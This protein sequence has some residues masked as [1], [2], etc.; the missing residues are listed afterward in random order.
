MLED[1]VGDGASLV[2]SLDSMSQR[3]LR[4]PLYTNCSGASISWI[5]PGASTKSAA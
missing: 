4:E 2:E 5:G 3:Y 1:S